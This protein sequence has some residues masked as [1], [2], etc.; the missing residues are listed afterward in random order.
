MYQS[1]LPPIF[2]PLRNVV[3]E[4]PAIK[5]SV[6]RKLEVRTTEKSLWQSEGSC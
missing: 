6:M 3:E 5:I 2:A 4:N 1:H